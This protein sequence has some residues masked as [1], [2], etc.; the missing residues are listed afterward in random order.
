MYMLLIDAETEAVFAMRCAGFPTFQR[1]VLIALIHMGFDICVP[2]YN[3]TVSVVI[4]L[5][6]CCSLYVSLQYVVLQL[7]GG[8]CCAFFS[9]LIAPVYSLL[10]PGIGY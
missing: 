7:C 6:S 2:Q 4:Y 10:V 9:K 3:P 1:C 5:R 8:V